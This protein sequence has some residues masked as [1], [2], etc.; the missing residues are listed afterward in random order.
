MHIILTDVERV[1]DA[2]KKLRN[3]YGHLIGVSYE[4]EQQREDLVIEE[5]ANA[6]KVSPLSLFEDF[7]ESANGKP[8]RDEQ[9]K[10]MTELINSIWS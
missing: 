10:I 1:P 6:E 5:A 3:V 8:M 7:F 2:Q 9:R 4:R